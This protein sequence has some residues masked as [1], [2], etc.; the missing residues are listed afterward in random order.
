ME[1]VWTHIKM[2]SVCS[3][4]PSNAVQFV[5]NNKR[6]RGRPTILPFTLNNDLKHIPGKKMTLTSQKDLN[7]IR[8]ITENREGWRTFIAEIRGA[9]KAVWS[10]YPTSE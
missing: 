1:T 5:E 4:K 7:L 3:G 2:R 9:G 10:D 8:D 6:Q